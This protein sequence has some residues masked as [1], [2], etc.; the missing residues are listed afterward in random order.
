MG[1][2]STGTEQTGM[3]ETGQGKI[4]A[5]AGQPRR[6]RGRLARAGA[7]SVLATG[8]SQATLIGLLL[9]G[10]SAPL[11]SGIAF[12][13]GAIPNYFLARRWAWGRRGKP[14]VKAELLPYL[15][16]IGIGWFASVGLTTAAAML[17][18]PLA[19]SG[20]WRIVVLDAAYLGGYA[21]V[22]ALK[23]AALDR[24]VYARLQDVEP[25]VP[26]LPPSHKVV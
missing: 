25:P 8:L 10:A 9:W 15:A 13:A 3:A 21:V 17:T 22:F 5:P 18:D 4:P 7:S 11:A 26:V 16:V 1:R 12:V 6:L 20:F 2:V 23:F 24:L 14:Q 19:L